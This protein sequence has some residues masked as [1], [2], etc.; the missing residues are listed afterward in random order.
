LLEP[1]SGT[2]RLNGYDI[3]KQ[4]NQV[5]Q[6]LGI[7]MAGERSVY[8]KLSGRENLEYFAWRGRPSCCW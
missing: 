6:S 5:R 2:A 4:P 1:T 7:V 8:W 3:L